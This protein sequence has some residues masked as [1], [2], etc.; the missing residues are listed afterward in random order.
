MGMAALKVWW[1]GSALFAEQGLNLSEHLIA[2]I[3]NL[4]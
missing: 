3:K 4:L 1:S 2:E